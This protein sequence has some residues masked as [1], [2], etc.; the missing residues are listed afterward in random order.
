MDAYSDHVDTLVKPVEPPTVPPPAT[1]QRSGGARRITAYLLAGLLLL[2]GGFGIG[3]LAVGNTSP[4]TTT[5]AGTF[6]PSLQPAVEPVAAVAAALL[7]ATVQLETASGLGSG[8][9][10]DPAGY[11]LTAAHVVDG[12]RSVTVRLADGT[13][14]EGT[15]VGTH[16]DSDVAVV[17]IDHSGL[18]AA[19]LATGVPLEVGQMAV[20]I[21]SPFG[22]DNTVTAGVV[23]SAAQALRGPNG[24]VQQMIQ[25]DAAINPGN[26]GGPLAN[27]EAQVIG[28]N[29]AIFSRSGGNEGVGFAIPI[30]TAKRIADQLVAGEPI[31]TAVLGVTGT[32]TTAGRP[33]ALIT[34]VIAGSAA[35]RAGLLVG[36]LVVE[37]DGRPVQGITDLAAN[38]ASAQ[39]E[40]HV[41]LEVIRGG[42]EIQIDAALGEA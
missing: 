26:S 20:A 31:K 40:D 22:L 30:D 27:R 29:D 4:T 24:S 14:Q 16:V 2:G 41:T 33:G 36:D 35:D 5:V 23:S 28:I 12:S 42:Q 8:F 15:V 3:R 1:P 13:Q 39:P 32:D 6:T 18:E 37:V 19:R 11:I 25:T 7:P 10:Y 17:K 34:G 38:I 21:G 9:I